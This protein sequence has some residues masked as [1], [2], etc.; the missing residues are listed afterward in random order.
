MKRIS[1]LLIL[2]FLF[3]FTYAEEHTHVDE[4]EVC[5]VKN[6]K[7]MDIVLQEQLRN[8]NAWQ[9]F[10]NNH[11]N[12]FVYFNENNLKPHRA[13]GE[14]I[15][16]GVGLR[17]TDKIENFIELELDMFSIPEDIRL[18]SSN[19]NDK[20]KHYNFNQYYK[21]LE[22]LDSRLYI[23]LSKDNNLITF[24][25]DVF[26]DIDIDINPIISS[27]EASELASQNIINPIENIYVE[28]KLKI[29]PVPKN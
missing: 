29:L 19:K 1:S 8:Q 23:K 9:L 24:G 15:D 4:Y 20:Y 22:V 12:W 21:E 17:I 3:C 13:F 10:L 28:E 26:S 2:L 11:P 5:Y 14:P 7:K 25:L 16:L 18:I 6:S 27:I